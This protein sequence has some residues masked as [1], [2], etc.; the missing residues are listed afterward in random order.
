M[1]GATRAAKMTALQAAIY[2]LVIDLIYEG[3]G[4]T[5]NDPAYFAAHYGDVT[6]DAAAGAVADLVG[7]SKLIIS[8]KNL[9]QERAR[10][11]AKTKQNVK[12]TRSKSGKIGGIKSGEARRNKALL[13]CGEANDE[14]K[15]SREDKRREDKKEREDPPTPLRGEA[16]GF[17]LIPVE[18][19]QE[20]FPQQAVERALKIYADMAAKFGLP[21]PRDLTPKRRQAIGA[22]IREF[23]EASWAEAVEKVG[24]SPFLRGEAGRDSWRGADI[25]WLSKPTNFI[26]VIEGKY[27]GPK[28]HP[29]AAGRGPSAGVVD[30]LQEAVR[31]AEERD[32]ARR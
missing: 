1:L 17:S 29:S 7:M 25:D 27:D 22:R 15:R 6:P 32:R 3:A 10:R 28:S 31:Q 24:G 30:D 19:A 23:G 21:I 26:K 2:N 11:E 18:P 13:N 4:E 9:T 12:Q 14:A 5:P 20:G 16:V 8:G